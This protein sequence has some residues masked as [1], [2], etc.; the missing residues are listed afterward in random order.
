MGAWEILRGDLAAATSREFERRALPVMRLFQ[1]DMIQA[2]ELAGLDRAGIDL[3]VWSDTR[4]FPWVV[5]CK[6]FKEFEEL[7]ESQTKQ[8]LKSIKKFHESPYSC[9]EYVL[10]HNRTGENR[11]AAAAINEALNA[12]REDGKATSAQLWDRQTLIK[13]AKR[14]LRTM[15]VDRMRQEAEQV[16]SNNEKLFRFGS[17]YVSDVPVSCQTLTFNP[18]ADLRVDSV[19]VY[20]V[21]ELILSQSKARWTMLTGPFGTGKTTTALHAARSAGYDVIYVRAEAMTER[22]GTEGTNVVFSRIVDALAVFDDFEDTTRTLASRLAGPTLAGVLK[23]RQ[24]DFALII[25]G[26]DENRIYGKAEGVRQLTNELAEMRC[27]IVLTTRKEHFD[28][29]FSNFERLFGKISQKGRSGRDARIFCL[30][31]W[32]NRA[33][34]ALLKNA[35]KIAKAEER[36]YLENFLHALE[37]GRADDIYG[38]LHRHPLFLQMILEEIASGIMEH[39]SRAELI[40]NWVERKIKRDINV[41]RMT[42]VEIVDEDSFVELMMTLQERVASRMTVSE[43]SQWSLTEHIGSDIVEREARRI[44]NDN[45]VDIS[46]VL[47]CSVLSAV[48]PRHRGQM[49]IRF[50]LRVCQEFFIAAYLHRTDQKPTGYPDPVV[51][52]WEELVE[53]SVAY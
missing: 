44:F 20:R 30:E 35:I 34:K 17:A 50:L 26:L 19:D 9:E 32:S 12:L 18:S 10:V 11:Q 23:G 14:R 13:L 33:V 5:Q 15:L 16:L 42:P 45:A 49:P 28:S 31:L 7:G 39:R 22:G 2:P 40:R 4:T 24:T 21:A 3:L 27:P 52:L 1:P 47:G 36:P 38:G 48:T 37:I 51:E 8:I 41:D 29:T 53:H 46:S 43:S 25:D 6:G